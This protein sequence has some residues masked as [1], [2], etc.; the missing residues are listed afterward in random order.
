MAK[1]LKFNPLAGLMGSINFGRLDGT[2]FVEESPIVPQGRAEDAQ[3]VPIV[4]YTGGE[5]GWCP[6]HTPAGWEQPTADKAAALGY[7]QSAGGW[8][9]PP[10]G[11]GQY[12]DWGELA[13][14]FEAGTAT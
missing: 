13:E 3:P 11:R 14:A 5:G 8:I 7:W 1:L 12:V 10:E 6:G 2:G 9:Y 4:R